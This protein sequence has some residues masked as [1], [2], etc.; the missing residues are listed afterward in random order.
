MLKRLYK[1]KL[2]WYGELHTFF[3]HGS[4]VAHAKRLAILAFSKKADLEF[5]Y[6]YSY[7]NNELDSCD[8]RI[9]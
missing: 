5:G 6:C 8:V 2:N 3:K 7:F 4:S 9:I 1:V